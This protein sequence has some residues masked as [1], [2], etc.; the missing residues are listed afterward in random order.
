MK[1]CQIPRV[2]VVSRKFV[3]QLHSFDIRP[4]RGRTLVFGF[5]VPL[6]HLTIDREVAVSFNRLL[7]AIGLQRNK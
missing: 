7:V 2:N 5:E 6:E 3:E 4:D 1:L